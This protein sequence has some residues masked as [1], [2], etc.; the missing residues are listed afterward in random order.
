MTPRL[1]WVLGYKLWFLGIAY[2]SCDNVWSSE[3]TLL[4]LQRPLTEVA[5]AVDT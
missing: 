1:I 4:C 5:C 3:G 2:I